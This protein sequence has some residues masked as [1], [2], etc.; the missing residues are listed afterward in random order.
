MSSG[1]FKTERRSHPRFASLSPALVV[2]EAGIAGQCLIEDLSIGGARIT[3][4]PGLVIGE[5]V[6]LLLQLPGRR[7][8]SMDGRIARQLPDLGTV[9]GRYGLSF[10]RISGPAQRDLDATVAALQ[11]TPAAPEAV[12]LV[13]D[14]SPRMCS[15]L[16]HDL[17]EMGRKGIAVTTPLDAIEWLLDVGSHIDAAFVDVMLGAASGCDLLSFLADEYPQVRRVLMADPLH[18]AHLERMQRGAEPHATLAKPWGA[19]DLQ[20]VLTIDVP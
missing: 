20:R 18:P 5:V 7:P 2:G 4:A 12:V 17:N 6:R 8:F 10:A 1:E 9:I 15:A 13:V 19:Q 11:L 3:G 16:V 14:D